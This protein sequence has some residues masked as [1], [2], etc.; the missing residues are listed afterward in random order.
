M[1]SP[2]LVLSA[3]SEPTPKAPRTTSNRALAL[4]SEMSSPPTHLRSSSA[5]PSAG[6]TRYAVLTAGLGLLCCSL[7][8]LASMV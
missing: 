6:W 8:A 7:W 3:P 1:G 2:K 4:W 5:R